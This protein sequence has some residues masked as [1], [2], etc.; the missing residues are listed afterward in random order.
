MTL[1]T[2]IEIYLKYLNL[3][4]YF[5]NEIFYKI[6]FILLLFNKKNIKFLLS[7][8]ENRK[9]FVQKEDYQYLSK[10][11]ILNTYNSIKTKKT[12]STLTN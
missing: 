11:K 1:I 9:K 6:L 2:F 12:P 8:P 4:I 5:Y 10:N 3:S 7:H